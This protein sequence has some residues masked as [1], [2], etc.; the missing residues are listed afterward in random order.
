[1]EG[2]VIQDLRIGVRMLCKSPGFTLVAVLTLALGIGANTAIFSVINSALIKPLPYP[3]AERLVNVW[4]MRPNGGRN[5]V[6]G[7]AFKDWRAHSAKFAHLAL[8]K[9][10]RLNLTG[11][12]APEHLSGLQV[13]TEFLSV[14]GVTPLLGRGFVAGEDATGGNNRVIIL[15]HQLWQRRYGGDAGV[16]GQTVSLNQIP[17]TVVGV[18]PPGAM[19]GAQLQDNAGFL[20]PI[21]VDVDTDT[22]GWSRGYHCCGVIG[23]VA[24]GVSVADAQ[25][26]L[27]GVKQRLAAEYPPS[28]KDWSVLVVRRSECCWRRWAWCC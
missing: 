14:L 23:R 12:G 20:I 19:L 16:I 27:R 11:T 26:D 2:E 21:I 4:E 17:Y 8:Y 6:S 5:G 18:L 3:G 13:S 9:D 15:A 22:V 24:P 25:A 10:V 1:L 28:K 7:G